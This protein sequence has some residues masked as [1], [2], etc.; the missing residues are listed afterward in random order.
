MAVL[1]E[2]F[3]KILAVQLWLGDKELSANNPIRARSITPCR[4]ASRGR[5]IAPWISLYESDERRR[6]RQRNRGPGVNPVNYSRLTFASR[7]ILKRLKRS[8]AM[9]RL[10]AE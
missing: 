6:L 3:T 5:I 2:E 4:D 8:A 7:L 10:D 1:N 9:E